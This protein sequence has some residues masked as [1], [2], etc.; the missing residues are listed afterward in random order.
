MKWKFAGKCR[1]DEREEEKLS[2]LVVDII[3]WMER[4]LFVNNVTRFNDFVSFPF[5]GFKI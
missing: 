2:L 3:E 1:V 5:L 4:G